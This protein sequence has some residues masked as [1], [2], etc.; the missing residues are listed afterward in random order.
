MGTDWRRASDPL[1]LVLQA[2]VSCL[3]WVLGA[4]LRPS[5]RA[6]SDLI[7]GT[8]SPPQMLHSCLMCFTFL[9]GCASGRFWKI[10]SSVVGGIVALCIGL[11]TSVYL[12]TLHENDLWFS[13]IK[14]WATLDRYYMIYSFV[15][16]R[17]SHVDKW[18]GPHSLAMKVQPTFLSRHGLH[19]CNPS[20]Q[21]EKGRSGI[22]RPAWV[23]WELVFPGK[24]R[25]LGLRRVWLKGKKT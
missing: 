15:S 23:M 18:P 5:A 22:Q 16:L 21:V 3:M 8:V 7:S 11:L 14:V 12:A 19:V 20:T 4:R 10:L 9:K 2:I 13:N 1:Q 25:I 24:K 17:A 6:A